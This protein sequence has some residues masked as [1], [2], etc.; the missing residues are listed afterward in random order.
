MYFWDRKRKGTLMVSAENPLPTTA[1][2]PKT[3]VLRKAAST[4]AGFRFW[5]ETIDGNA[6]NPGFG[7]ATKRGRRIILKNN[8]DVAITQIRAYCFLRDDAGAELHR[9]QAD[10]PNLAA[11]ATLVIDSANFQDID[12]A[13]THISLRTNAT[14]RTTGDVQVI[15]VSR[16][17]L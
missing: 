7:I 5:G 17:Y 14:G 16:G 10:F 13:W 6:N 3:E 1:I 11:G 2:E 4:V 12:G 8:T 15:Y 9:A